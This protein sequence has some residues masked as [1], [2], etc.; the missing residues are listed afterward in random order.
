MIDTHSYRLM[1]S[2][3]IAG[4]CVWLLACPPSV[5]D[6][7]RSGKSAFEQAVEQG[8]APNGNLSEQLSGEGFAIESLQ[9]IKAFVG[10]IRRMN[11]VP[12]YG[13]P[14]WG[15]LS[16]LLSA[17][18][19]RVKDPDDTEDLNGRKLL[20]AEAGSALVDLADRLGHSAAS[21]DRDRCLLRTLEL[22]ALCNTAEGKER[23]LKYARENV[24][25]DE[26]VWY[27]I[28]EI[29]FEQDRDFCR[30]LLK[31]LSD[32]LPSGYVAAGYLKMCNQLAME[33]KEF[34]HP[35][36]SEQGLQRMTELTTDRFQCYLYQIEAAATEHIAPEYADTFFKAMIDQNV[37]E[38]SPMAALKS[39]QRNLPS[40]L[41]SLQAMCSDLLHHHAV[42]EHLKT[43]GR[44]DL[45]PP[46]TM[47]PEF[48]ARAA[49]ALYLYL[50]ATEFSTDG[51]IEI[52]ARREFQWPGEAEKRTFF[53]IRFLKE[54]DDPLS[55]VIY[56][57]FNGESSHCIF[58]KEMDEWTPEDA[59]ARHF[60]KE[61]RYR[62][63]LSSPV[64]RAVPAHWK[65]GT[66]RYL[67]DWSELSLPKVVNYPRQ[68]DQEVENPMIVAVA[69]ENSGRRG[70][71]VFD[72][73]R[74]EWYD[75][76]HF[77]DHFESEDVLDIHVGRVVLG[78]PHRVRQSLNTQRMYRNEFV[79][80]TY[81]AWLSQIEAGDVSARQR[82]LFDGGDF[83]PNPLALHLDRYLDAVARVRG[84]DRS[85]HFVTTY[86][87]IL[88]VASQ[89]PEKDALSVFSSRTGLRHLESYVTQVVNRDTEQGKV[90][91]EMAR[92][93]FEK[94]MLE[95]DDQHPVEAAE[96]WF[97]D[98]DR[99]QALKLL[100]D[101]IQSAGVGDEIYSWESLDNARKAL[102]ILTTLEP[103]LTDDELRWKDRVPAYLLNESSPTN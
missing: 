6:E 50:N 98:G 51:K 7:A 27:S 61:I 62:F 68:E 9:D 15:A 84:G 69:A 39:A 83:P 79:I 103:Q 58:D 94:A 101:V 80:Q 70:F 42:R 99:D 38:Y 19:Y 35:F 4:F 102:R 91:P 32:P 43:L 96:L 81:E 10:A 82:L 78:L 77:P 75:R 52:K 40:G 3:C 100:S 66:L 71:A 13:A 22:L 12:T 2:A 88:K 20:V 34:T 16:S 72:G 60:G 1:R 93:Y 95:D 36:N 85:N 45:V 14:E 11:E 37:F 25:V 31:E 18:W 90:L 59:F 74:S 44:E 24:G 41:Q 54:S 48:E 28:F 56:V 30:T 47:S 29:Y 97:R 55:P 65:K 49:F 23:V 46:D 33:Q 76:K 53:L 86:E 92:T 67:H 73:L 26:T 21:P 8:L 63:G 87:R 89:L 57:G 5:S 17:A 64:S